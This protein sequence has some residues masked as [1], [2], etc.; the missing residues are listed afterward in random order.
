[1][2]YARHGAQGTF[3]AMTAAVE[4]PEARRTRTL[5]TLPGAVSEARRWVASVTEGLLAADQAES[6]RLV[7]SE[8]V[9]NALR[10]GGDGRPI[11]LAVTPK[12]DFLCVQ[13]TDDGP[14]LAP[15]PRALGARRRGR[16]RPVLRRAAHAPLGHDAREPAHARLVRA[17]LSL[18]LPGTSMGDTDPGASSER[19]P[20]ADRGGLA[21]RIAGKAK[22]AAGSMTGN[23][24]LAREGRLQQA[25]ADAHG[26][27]EER[28]AEA[29]AAEQEAQLAEDR[30]SNER[31]RAELENELAAEQR[32]ENAER[33]RARAEAEAAAEAERRATA[34]DTERRLS[35]GAARADERRAVV[36]EAQDLQDA[37]ALERQARQADAR[38]DAVDPEERWTWTCEAFPVPPSARR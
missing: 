16:L 31:E 19:H 21:G 10:H 26:E 8:L 18:S 27:A 3:C 32:D 5:P 28:R 33:D 25:A 17:R 14:G 30:A 4:V 13:V 24:D 29:R 20:R 11:D 23:D 15:R 7:I 22:Q 34:A 12:P 1:M 38:A 6:L 37:A 9:T 35:E 36:D 2:R